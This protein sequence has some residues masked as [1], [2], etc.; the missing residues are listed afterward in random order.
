MRANMVAQFCHGHP[1]NP[2]RASVAFDRQPGRRGILPGDHLFHQV[3]LYIAFF[4]D[5]R[6]RVPCLPLRTLEAAAPPGRPLAG[7]GWR[8]QLSLPAVSDDSQVLFQ[9]VVE[10][11]SFVLRPFARPGFRRALIATM[12]SADFRRPLDP[13]IPWV[14]VAP[15]LSRRRVLPDACSYDLWASLL[16]ASLPLHPASLLVRVPAAKSSLPVLSS[17]ALRP[18]SN[19]PLRLASSPPSGSFH[20][21]SP[22]HLPSTRAHAPPRAANWRP[23]RLV[24]RVQPHCMVGS[25]G[26]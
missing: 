26:L 6:K 15:F 1:V 18:R 8:P 3:L 12:A 14:S 16:L 23:R 19:L 17:C 21:A 10:L 24:W 13:R 9:S 11:C 2:R 5:F 20:P 22:Q 7:P 4:G 25:I